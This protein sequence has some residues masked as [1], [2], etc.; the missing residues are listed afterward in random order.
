MN[1]ELSEQLRNIIAL[2]G[3]LTTACIAAERGE[4]SVGLERSAHFIECQLQ[5]FQQKLEAATAQPDA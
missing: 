3:I 2:Q 4:T 5:D 1:N